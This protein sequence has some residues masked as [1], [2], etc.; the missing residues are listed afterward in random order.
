MARSGCYLAL[1]TWRSGTVAG[2]WCVACS[3]WH[4]VRG[5]WWVTRGAWYV[6]V[7]QLGHLVCHFLTHFVVVLVKHVHLA[8][9]SYLDCTEA[10]HNLALTILQ[11]LYA[12]QRIGCCTETAWS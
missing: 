2:A 8:H 12:V 4:V 6:V 11:C 7:R 5:V 3:G 1:G 9:P 10:L